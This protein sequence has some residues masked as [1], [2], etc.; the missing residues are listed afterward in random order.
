[1]HAEDEYS[2]VS[3]RFKDDSSAD[4]SMFKSANGCKD[5]NYVSLKKIVNVPKLSLLRKQKID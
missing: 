5:E 2:I 4:A 3:P 1:L